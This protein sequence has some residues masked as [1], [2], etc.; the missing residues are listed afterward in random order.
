MWLRWFWLMVKGGGL[1]MVPGVMDSKAVGSPIATRFDMGQGQELRL[2]TLPGTRYGERFGQALTRWPLHSGASPWVVVSAP[3]RS[4]E[5]DNHGGISVL[6]ETPEGQWT[7][8]DSP[9]MDR[10][11]RGKIGYALSGEGDFNGDGI[12]EL[13][14]GAPYAGNYGHRAGAVVVMDGVIGS[15]AAATLTIPGF[16]SH[17]QFGLTLAMVGDVNG[18]QFDDLVVGAPVATGSLEEEGS[19]FLYLGSPQ[20]LSTQSLWRAWGGKKGQRLGE[21]VQAAGDVN[22]DGFADVL[23][24]AP[25]WDAALPGHGEV[26]LYVGN[27]QGL[28]AEPV[29]TYRSERPYARAGRGLA[30]GFDINGDGLADLMVGLPGRMPVESYPG[31]A[32]IHFFFGRGQGPSIEPDLVWE[33]PVRR[34]GFGD[35]ICVVG[36][37]NGD[38]FPELAVGSPF[39]ALVGREH[40]VL[41]IFPG[42]AEG[43][44]T[45]PML[46]IKGGLPRGRYGSEL[47]ALGDLDGDGLADLGIGSPEFAS[48]NH[49]NGRCDILF[50]SRGLGTRTVSLEALRVPPILLQGL[51]LTLAAAM[52]TR[53]PTADLPVGLVPWSLTTWML[54]GAAVLVSA[55]L[56]VAWLAAHGRV[57]AIRYR[58]HDFVGSEL[59]RLQPGDRRLRRVADELRATIWTV[60]QDRP[61]ASGLIGAMADWAWDYAQEQQFTLRLDLPLGPNEHWPVDGHVAETAQAAVRIAMANVV[62]HARATSALLRIRATE[63][64]LTL[65]VQD[66]GGGFDIGI[67]EG[68]SLEKRGHRGLLTLRRRVQGLGGRFEV[69]SRAGGGTQFRVRL[70]NRAGRSGWFGLL[71]SWRGFFHRIAFRR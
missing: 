17:A 66:D 60:K 8:G 70:P 53:I 18:D 44:S 4:G 30:R 24:A 69:T 64:D 59:S 15:P 55:G 13:V 40:G 46:E 9:F 48:R 61:T 16:I 36:D 43:F 42:I 28:S 3:N 14:V 39:T 41:R 52:E 68:P 49:A 2:I 37:M 6:Q 11:P 23:V 19:V 67:L 29:W 54:L 27:P 22:G 21:N 33:S 38:G 12:P 50:G 34:D 10:I 25:R 5:A 71:A 56:A 62:E 45:E 7:L 31:G 58:L 1:M 63:T 57:Q 35:A 51:D 65:E 32:E 47:T 20:G 26:R